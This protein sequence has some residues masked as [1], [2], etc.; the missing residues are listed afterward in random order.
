LNHA[1][2]YKTRINKTLFKNC[3]LQECDFTE[4]EFTGSSFDNC[5]LSGAMFEKSNLEKVDFRTSLNFFID[6][7]NNK[8]KKAKFSIQ[9]LPG[10]LF[11]YG[12]EVEE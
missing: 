9:G 8:L 3:Q 1:S 4:G 6:P 2:F 12:I 11:K 10:L 5:D 7:E